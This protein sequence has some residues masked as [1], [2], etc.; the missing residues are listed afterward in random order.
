MKG[1]NSC[2]LFSTS[3]AI[4]YNIDIFIYKKQEESWDCCCWSF[5]WN[6]A[7]VGH[8]VVCGQTRAEMWAEFAMVR[9][10]NSKQNSLSFGKYCLSLLREFAS[11]ATAI[12][13]MVISRRQGKSFSRILKSGME[14]GHGFDSISDDSNRRQ[15]RDQ[16]LQCLG[17]WFPK[18]KHSSERYGLF[19][20]RKSH[21]D[22]LSFLMLFKVKISS[23]PRL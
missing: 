13:M 4:T 22:V 19:Q 23:W 7:A 20:G 14:P 16:F 3:V 15:F 1:N 10:E 2:W 11:S 8:M 12:N 17:I 9:E 5:H 6:T 21:L 18:W